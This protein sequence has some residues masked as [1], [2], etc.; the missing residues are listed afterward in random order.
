MSENQMGEEHFGLGSKGICTI[1][2]VAV[3][4]EA[5]C[6]LAQQSADKSVVLL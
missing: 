5:V 2:S 6:K 4:L 3:S 1:L